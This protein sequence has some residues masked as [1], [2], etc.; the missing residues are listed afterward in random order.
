MDKALVERRDGE[1]EVS[2]NGLVKD[3]LTPD[4]ALELASAL[5][6]ACGVAAE[7]YQEASLCPLTKSR[8]EGDGCAWWVE[9]HGLPG[10]CAVATLARHH[11]IAGQ[12]EEPVQSARHALR[13]IR[14]GTKFVATCREGDGDEA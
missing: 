3:V 9:G 6:D 10:R 14:S 12:F 1:I 11:V 13:C 8:C 5:R 2:L 7:D 4:E